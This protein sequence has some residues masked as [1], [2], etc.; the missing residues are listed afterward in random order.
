MT[1]YIINTDSHAIEEKERKTKEHVEQQTTR[2]FAFNEKN[3]LNT[4]LTDGELEKEIKVR[5]LP[6]SV[7]NGD[8]FFALHI[9]SIM[10]DKAISQSGFKT[11][12]CLNDVNLPEHDDR[13]CPFC[14]KSKELFKEANTTTNEGEKKTLIKSAYSYQNKIAYIVRVIERGK[15]DEGVKFWRF[16]ARTD[17][18]GIYDKL[19][20]I[21]KQRKEEAEMAGQ[22][23]YSIFD[24][25]NGRDITI[26][27]N[28]VPST[29]KTTIDI[30]DSGF[31]TPLSRDIELANKW[32]SDS[33]N[34][35]DVYALK[36]Y[37][38]MELVAE[39]KIPV[40]DTTQQKWVERVDNSTYSGAN[41]VNTQSKV[42]T[43]TQAGIEPQPV[44]PDTYVEEVA[45]TQQQYNTQDD[46]LP[47]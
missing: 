18:Q 15:E 40:F 33:K 26:K 25:N 4:R 9:H 28:Y 43:I 19:M 20:K 2:K 31:Q 10:V 34:W 39:G 42:T 14:N 41:V 27:L 1:N 8:I 22:P 47:F 3:Y 38:Y 37:D 5:I 36:S 45:T 21:Y 35:R 23:N 29:K 46:D 11:F 16:N 30:I 44:Y 12:V 13:G 17:G 32:I 6:V 7:T 24:L